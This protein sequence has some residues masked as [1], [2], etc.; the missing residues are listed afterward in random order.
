MFPTLLF[1]RGMARALY[2]L[3]TMTIAIGDLSVLVN[4]V[5]ESFYLSKVKHLENMFK[6]H[7]YPEVETRFHGV[8]VSVPT[9]SVW[10]AGSSAQP[11]V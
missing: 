1:S 6:L 7:E 5:Q 11:H 8:R 2:N 9:C 3:S 10:E 4:A